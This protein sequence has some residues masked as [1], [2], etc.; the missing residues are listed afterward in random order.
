MQRMRTGA[1]KAPRVA[2]SDARLIALVMETKAGMERRNRGPEVATR[3]ANHS[4]SGSRREMVL[5]IA[6][7]G[8]AYRSSAAP[9]QSASVS[10]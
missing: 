4:A 8:N 6:V 2:L 5:D 9:S 3:T 1:F 10:G 7:R